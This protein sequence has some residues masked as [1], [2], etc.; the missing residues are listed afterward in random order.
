MNKSSENHSTSTKGF[1][2]NYPRENA[3]AADAPD[4]LSCFSYLSGLSINFPS[5]P[6][7]SYSII[8]QK[9]THQ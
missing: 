7:A 8:V 6:K 4:N 9:Q 5:S 3:L 2:I 1:H